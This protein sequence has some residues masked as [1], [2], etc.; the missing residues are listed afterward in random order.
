MAKGGVRLNKSGICYPKVI[1]L[2]K[3]SRCAAFQANH[4]LS[5]IRPARHRQ[6]C[7]LRLPATV[8]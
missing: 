6:L 4:I 3:S 1:P 2:G 5:H 8:L 7:A